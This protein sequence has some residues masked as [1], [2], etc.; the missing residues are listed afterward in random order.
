MLRDTAKCLKM[1]QQRKKPTEA[2]R[3]GWLEFERVLDTRARIL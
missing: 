2:H 3:K 1:L